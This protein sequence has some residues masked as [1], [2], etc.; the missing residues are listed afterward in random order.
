[1]FQ[2]LNRM[3]KHYFEWTTG[4]CMPKMAVL[5]LLLVST[6]IAT[7][8]ESSKVLCLF[9]ALKI[10]N[11]KQCELSDSLKYYSIPAVYNVW[12]AKQSVR[13]QEA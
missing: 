7:G 10:P 3:F 9:Q 11:L 5:Y 12:S 1:M 8:M 4:P 6:I 13:L 2:N